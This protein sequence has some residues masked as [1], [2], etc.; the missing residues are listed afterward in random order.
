MSGTKPYI[1]FEQA[2]S[3]GR[4]TVVYRVMSVHRG[5]QLGIICWHGPWRQ[6]VFWPAEGTYWSVGCLAD[7]QEFIAGLM[8]EWR[9]SR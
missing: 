3:L 6:Y 8:A 4:K 2:P 9:G 5:T 7:V 1:R